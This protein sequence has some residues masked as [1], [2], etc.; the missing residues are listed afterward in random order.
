MTRFSRIKNYITLAGLCLILCVGQSRAGHR[1]LPE[2]IIL[3]LTETP[4]ISQAVTWRTGEKSLSQRAEI[5]PVS[6]L[7]NPEIRPRSF[8]ALSTPVA[9]DDKA[10]VFQYSVVFNDLIPDRI[11]AYRVGDDQAWSEWNQFKTAQDKPEP[12]TFLYFG[13][14]QEEV[15]SMCSQIFRAAFQK[16]PEARFWL[17]AGDM[18]D[19][20]PDDRLWGEFFSAL[21]WISRTTPLVLAA[22]NHE[23]PDPR[24]IP[25]D[26]RRITSLWRPQF[27]LPENGPEGLEETVF[28]F[29][30]QGVRVVVLNGNQKIQEQALWLE[31]VLSNNPQAWTIVVIHQPVYP[32]S[33]RK[34]HTDFQHLL[35]PVFDRYSVDLALKGHDHGYARTVSL[36]NHQPVSEKEKG[37]VY[38]ITN[39]GPKF[40]PAGDRY[41]YLMAKT[42]SRTMSFQSV[43]VEGKTLQYRAYN[44]AKEMVDAFEM[45]K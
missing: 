2:R 11:Y 13:D 28:S 22:G 8:P 10:G 25:A 35:V 26:Q 29:D 34:T 16:E 45:K 43:R 1:A 12:F 44:L 6:D 31:G 24:K 23:Y 30:Y 36:K 38:I 40:Y 17:F 27:T 18:V 19:N 33:Q 42:L 4:F 14:V 20:G 5:I 37:V 32:I 39:S 15:F 9:L 21:G 3:N 41:G 7:L